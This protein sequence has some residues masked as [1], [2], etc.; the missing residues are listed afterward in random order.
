MFPPAERNGVKIPGL[1][2]KPKTVSSV[3]IIGAGL[4]GQGI[5]MCCANIGQSVV[6]LD[7]SQPAVD[8]GL[9]AIQSN[10]SRS[11]KKGSRLK[12]QVDQNLFF[13][14]SFTH[15][16]RASFQVDRALA[17]IKATTNYDDLS[18]VDLV[19]EAVFEVEFVLLLDT[20][21]P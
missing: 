18:N 15:M 20:R 5:A 2:A 7:I 19:V 12:A 16:S 10:Y 6:F 21:I 3:G 1:K 4:M 9:R 14:Q 13:C 11:L 8:K 17:C